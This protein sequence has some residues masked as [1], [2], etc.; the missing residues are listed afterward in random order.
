[1]DTDEVEVLHKIEVQSGNKQA[2]ICVLVERRTMYI[3]GMPKRSINLTM[4][5]GP[6]KLFIPRRVATELGKALE[7]AASVASGAY[8]DLLETRSGIEAE[9]ILRRARSKK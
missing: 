4:V 9:N 6:K 7:Q 1:M 5:A 2:S 8:T 3:D